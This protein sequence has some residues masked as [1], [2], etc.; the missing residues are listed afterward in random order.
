MTIPAYTSEDFQQ[1][2][3]EIFKG[4]IRIDT[5]NPPGGETRAVHYLM[6]ILKAHGIDSRCLEREPQRGNLIA[7]LGGQGDKPPIFLI[8]HL[9]VVPAD[10]T[11][12]QHDPFSAEEF[13][14]AIWGRGALDT[15]QLTAMQVA[16]LLS[17]KRSGMALNRDVY[18]IASADEEM[19][20]A[21]G[22]KWLVTQIPELLKPALVISEGGG[23]PITTDNHDFLLCAAGEKGQCRIKITA[24]G[25]GGHASSPPNDQAI[26]ELARGLEKICDHSFTKK[27]SPIVRNFLIETGLN[28][29]DSK[30]NQTTL[31]ALT[32]H[33]LL[34]HWAVYE[35]RVG[36]APNAIP[37][38]AEVELNLHLLPGTSR[39]EVE[40]LL[41][42]LFYSSPLQWEIV[43]FQEGYES[44][45]Q[46][47]MLEA[48]QRNCEKFG[49][50]GTVLPF[51]ALGRTDG[52][53]LTNPGTSIYGF[54]PVLQEDNFPEVLQRVHGDNERIAVRSFRFGTQ[55]MAQTLLDLCVD[56]GEGR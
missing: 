47:E 11:R 9:D 38:T 54:S 10:K 42:R 5:A 18:L 36:S 35:I 52:R 48:F 30:I 21:L 14:G 55:V 20:S 12:W 13:D 7:R 6:G 41:M 25:S 15:K 31:G 56:N 19:G 27:F 29:S 3:L 50:N 45:L 24:S 17:L 39:K 53:F 23:F 2:A 44:E 1:E 43:S 16:A 37:R 32:Q 49:F 46:S 8:S 40:S 22:M 26:F 34:C 28:P 33:M 4:L 51:T